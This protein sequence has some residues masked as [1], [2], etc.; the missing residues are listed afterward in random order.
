MFRVASRHDRQ[1]ILSENWHPSII[2]NGSYGGRPVPETVLRRTRSVAETKAAPGPPFIGAFH[3][4]FS[5]TVLARSA[6][7]HRN[8][9]GEY[10]L[11]VVW[12]NVRELRVNAY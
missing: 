7:V 4:C 12:C 6:V 5:H 10:V 2:T 8:E 3:C 1:T 11:R 9:G